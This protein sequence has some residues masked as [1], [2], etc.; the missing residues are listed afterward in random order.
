MMLFVNF[1]QRKNCSKF[2]ISLIFLM[3]ALTMHLLS[4]LILSV[5]DNRPRSEDGVECL[6]NAE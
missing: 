6:C 4:N 2:W 1:D 3:E 5:L